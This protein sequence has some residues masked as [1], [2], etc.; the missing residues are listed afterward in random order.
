MTTKI[1]VGNISDHARS[2]ELRQL[3]EQYGTV[4]ECDILKNFGFVHME[5]ADDANTAIEKL[6]GHPFAGTKINVELSSS[7]GSKGRGGGRGGRGGRGGGRNGFGPMKGGRG[8]RSG[9]Y[10]RDRDGYGDGYRDRDY[11]GRRGG[12][13][14]PYGRDPYYDRRTPPMDMY[15][16]RDPYARGGRDPYYDR[17]YDRE[18][19]PPSRSYYDRGSDPYGSRPPPDYYSRGRGYEEAPDRGYGDY[20]RTEAAPPSSAAPA[21]N[22]TY[23]GSYSS[24]F[25]NDNPPARTGYGTTAGTENYSSFG[26]RG[27]Y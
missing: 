8:G 22:G 5:S 14:D 7:Q 13:D 23:G 4:K 21:T 18:P 11:Y 6:H 9:P 24:S 1:F 15:D 27:S 26:S 10:S 19:Y 17:Y 12:Y 25:T 2:E 16:R 20:A 3:F